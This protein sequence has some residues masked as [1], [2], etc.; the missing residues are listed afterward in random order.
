[1]KRKEVT[2][3][4]VVFVA[5]GFLF[6]L[7]IFLR[8]PNLT[9]FVVFEQPEDFDFDQGDYTNVE[10]NGSAIVL[11]SGNTTGTYTSKIFDATNDAVWNNI[12]FESIASRELLGNQQGSLM[13]GNVLL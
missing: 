9:G 3:Y 13:A 6:S 11:S 1:M 12:S 8:Q 7:L 2:K 10:W 5:F 4:L